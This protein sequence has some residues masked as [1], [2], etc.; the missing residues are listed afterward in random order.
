MLRRR[1]G[2]APRPSLREARRGRCG[3]IPACPFKGLLSS[4]SFG[5]FP[6]KPT[7]EGK[8]YQLL[9]GLRSPQHPWLDIDEDQPER[10]VEQLSQRAKHIEERREVV[11]QLLDEEDY[12][13]V[14]PPAPGGSAYRLVGGVVCFPA[15][16][17]VLEKLGQELPRV[18]DPVP[19]W[20][21]DA[22]HLVHSFMSRLLPERPF[23][24]WNWTLMPTPELH[25]SSFYT[26][27]PPSEP[28]DP[29]SADGLWLRLER[30]YFH[31]LPRSR[32]IVFTIR[33]YQQPLTT[34]VADRPRVAE[35]L[36][37]ALRSLPQAHLDYKVQLQN[38]MPALLRLLDDAA[39]A[40]QRVATRA[41]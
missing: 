31:R 23:L 24:R 9:L 27:P 35:A 25:L 8:P 7:P 4:Q 2:G 20:R 33:T 32:C 22:A 12:C 39:A 17:S 40:P 5:D 18:H 21:S 28:E 13:L 29:T 3:P 34:A 30:Q 11:I 16:W 36:A 37:G 6:F 26:P 38:R 41:G 14:A 19:R 15:H 10:F 1:T